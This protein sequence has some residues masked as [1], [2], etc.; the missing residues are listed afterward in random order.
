MKNKERF[1]DELADLALSDQCIAVTKGGDLTSCE[2][3]EC[4]DCMFFKLGDDGVSKNCTAKE[5]VKKWAEE[6][7]KE[8]ITVRSVDEKFIKMCTDKRCDEC[9]YASHPKYSCIF[10]WMFDN[11]NITEKEKKNEE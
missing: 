8:P 7:Y 4:T 6:E 5:D 1:K 11:Y 3:I 9:K 10:K 2:A